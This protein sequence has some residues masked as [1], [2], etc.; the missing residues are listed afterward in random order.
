MLKDFA[1]I[2]CR[3]GFQP[4]KDQQG[5]NRTQNFL[6]IKYVGLVK[7]NNINPKG[8]HALIILVKM[9]YFCFIFY[10]HV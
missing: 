1:R 9:D 10:T 3:L 2:V 5:I 4:N 6:E 8:T 7:P